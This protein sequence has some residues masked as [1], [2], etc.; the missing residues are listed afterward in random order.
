M[1][2]GST[3]SAVSLPYGTNV[4]LRETAPSAITGVTWGT[5]VWTGTGVTTVSGTARFTIGDGTNVSVGVANP[6]TRNNGSFIVTKSVT[7]SDSALV[8]GSTSFTVEYS[9]DGGTSWTPITVTP[10][11]PAVP[12]TLPYG[13]SVT[14]REAVRPVITGLTWGTPTGPS[15]ELRSRHYGHLLHR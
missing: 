10:G 15:T 13:T 7:G 6:T 9:T 1:T 11:L 8:P 12:V 2:A 5:P 3:T 14:V 4:K